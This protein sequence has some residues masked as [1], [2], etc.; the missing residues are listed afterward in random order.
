VR[1]Q[2]AVVS[3]EPQYV[4]RAPRADAQRNRAH[5]IEA[6]AAAFAERGVEASLEEVARRAGV[7]IGT[8]YRHFPS[9]DA[10][11]VA[12]Y[13]T[14]VWELCTSAEDLVQALPADEALA[15]WMERFVGRLAGKRG[16]VDVVRRMVSAD[17]SIF[18]EAFNQL[19]D[20]VTHLLAAARASGVVRREITPM[21]FLRLVGGISLTSDGPDWAEHARLQIAIV[22]DGLRCDG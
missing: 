2:S 15:A 19:G 8:L 14:E 16:M 5:L 17:A 6:A 10:L 1:T 3:E 4:G 20:A 13:R 11:V 22:L 18:D 21:T 7:G 12:V 9:R